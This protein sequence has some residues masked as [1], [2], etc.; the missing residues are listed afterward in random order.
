MLEV[1]DL[2]SRHHFILRDVIFIE[3]KFVYANS[4]VDSSLTKNEI[5]NYPED[6]EDSYM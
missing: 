3:T 6:D 5:V 2:E 4:I 1:I